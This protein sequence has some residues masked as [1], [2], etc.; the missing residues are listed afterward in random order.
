MRPKLDHE[1]G[2]KS[3]FRVKSAGRSSVST[4]RSGLLATGWRTISVGW[5]LSLRGCAMAQRLMSGLL[6]AVILGLVAPQPAVAQQDQI[7]S[8]VSPGSGYDIVKYD[9]APD[10][11]SGRTCTLWLGGT[12]VG[13]CEGPQ[14]G[15][16]R[17]HLTVRQGHP[18][19]SQ[20]LSCR[21]CRW[22]EGG[23][24][25]DTDPPTSSSSSSSSSS[26]QTP[27]QITMPDLIGKTSNDAQS[28][29]KSLDWFGAWNEEP[30][31]TTCDEIKQTSDTIADQSPNPGEPL[32]LEQAVTVY[33]CSPPPATDPSTPV[34]G[35]RRQPVEVE[36]Q[37]ATVVVLAE[38]VPPPVSPASSG[39]TPLHWILLLVICVLIIVTAI[40]LRFMRRPTRY[41]PV[42]EPYA[43]GWSP[44]RTRTAPP[45]DDRTRD[46][47]LT[48]DD[49]TLRSITNAPRITVQPP[50][51]PQ[52]AHRIRLA[53]HR[54]P[55]TRTVQEDHHGRR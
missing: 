48:S 20:A 25:P 39:L 1:H 33:I 4:S 30:S 6:T 51:G 3:L 16:L 8:E 50:G 44:P 54:D 49:V 37:V 24:P 36:I 5:F 46:W 40:G 9:I 14:Q 32:G 28:V 35:L 11:A 13:G 17:G 53:V 12:H 7:P 27:S 45:P 47:D 23:G 18:A 29:M 42:T 31:E 10:E 26:S 19:G 21:N 15:P 43:P 38:S 41:R 52:H 22:V 2:A 55:G 34:I